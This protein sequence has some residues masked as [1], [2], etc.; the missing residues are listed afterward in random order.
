[1]KGSLFLAAALAVVCAAPVAAHVPSGINA[2]Q[3]ALSWSY[4]PEVV[5]PLC[6]LGG[7]W[8]MGLLRLAGRARSGAAT[9]SWPNLAFAAGWLGLALALVSPLHAAGERS[10]LAHMAEHE[11]LMLAAAPLLALS[12][13]AGILLWGLPRVW[14][15]SVAGLGRARSLRA[16]WRAA[17]RPAV[18]TTI[19]GGLLWLWHL[20]ALFDAA[21]ASK[22]VHL[23]QHASFFGSAVLF[24]WALFRGGARQ[25]EHGVAVAAIFLTAVHSSLLGALLV[26]APRPLYQ[27]Y[28]G[29][30][31]G[32]S[33]LEDQQLAGLVMWVPAGIGY[34]VIGLAMLALWL[35]ASG[36]ASREHA[37]VAAA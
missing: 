17:T 19:H 12:R 15:K 28:S 25:R 20:P 16:G 33:P 37:H 34:T 4:E 23:A 31:F 18:A 2:R 36:Q 1:M 7:V 29:A 26:V 3:P 5:L 22:T 9:V 21:L 32:L 8:V 13:P 24:W 14:R 30:L 35:R 27:S 11:L 10:F 6:I